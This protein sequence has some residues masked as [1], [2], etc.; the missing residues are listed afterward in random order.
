MSY[1]NIIFSFEIDV[2]FYF[3][4]WT[5]KAGKEDRLADR[6]EDI[7]VDNNHI[8]MTCSTNIK[9]CFN[10]ILYTFIDLRFN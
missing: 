7:A 5:D 9:V 8:D 3:F 2:I 6:V 10:D 4:R 1:F